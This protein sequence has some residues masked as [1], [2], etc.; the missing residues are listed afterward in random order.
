[1]R[2]LMIISFIFIVTLFSQVDPLLAQNGERKT[3]TGQLQQESKEPQKE[4]YRRKIEQ[5]LTELGDRLK[6]LKGEAEKA[7]EKA[8]VKFQ[9]ASKDFDKYMESAKRNFEKIKTESA[10]TWEEAKAK[11]D[12]LMKELERSYERLAERW[13]KP[14]DD[15]S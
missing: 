14:S 10:K 3:D 11:M 13:N 7:G 8:K 9:E 4:E 12:F 1:M 5:K 2:S 15:K 6:A